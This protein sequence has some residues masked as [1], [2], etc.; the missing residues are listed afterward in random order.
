[1]GR[2]KAIQVEVYQIACCQ[3][4]GTRN[5]AIPQYFQQQKSNFK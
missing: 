4:E 1:M 3:D 5:V 2:C